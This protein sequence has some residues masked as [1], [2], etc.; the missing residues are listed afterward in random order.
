[1]NK[2]GLSTLFL[3][4]ITSMASASSKEIANCIR[5]I[6]CKETI[7]V[8]H[9][10]NGFGNDK[11]AP[12]NSRE[13]VKRALEAG[14]KIIEITPFEL[15]YDAGD[16]FKEFYHCDRIETIDTERNYP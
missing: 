5:D 3:L 6:A 11:I 14:V 12:E 8:A 2:I 10:A 15:T 16:H 4:T 1:M 13:A 7:I 9:R